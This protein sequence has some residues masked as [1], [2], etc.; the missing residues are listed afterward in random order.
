VT[1]DVSHDVCYRCGYALTGI[2]DEQPCPECGLLARR[3]RRTTDELRYTR[4]R[5]LRRLSRG[6]NLLL[7]AI[8][9]TAA[10]PVI[11][12]AL[13]HVANRIGPRTRVAPAT[14]APLLAIL[15]LLAVDVAALLVF[16]GAWLLS[17]REGYGPAD[18]AD[19]WLRWSLRLAAFALVVTIAGLNVERYLLFRQGFRGVVVDGVNAIEIAVNV[20]GFCSIPLPLLLFLVLRGLARRARSAH[21]AEHCAIVGVGGSVALLAFLIMG[22]LVRYGDSFGLAHRWVRRSQTSLLIVL[23]LFVAAL[24]F[25]I[26]SVYLLM[27]FAIAFR[28]TSRGLRVAWRDDDR[29]AGDVAIVA[30]SI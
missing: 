23:I 3:S 4:P 14:L 20:G 19:R 28:R 22:V 26:W 27:R 7:I 8:V 30:K 1:T 18:R 11:S 9:L 15:P 16:A 5:W 10:S 29:A 12:L 24:L 6:T 2:G 13:L 21:L 25:A 17:S